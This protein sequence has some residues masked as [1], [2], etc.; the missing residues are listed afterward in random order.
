MACHASHA[1]RCADKK[2]ADENRVFVF[3][4]TNSYFQNNVKIS[5]TRQSGF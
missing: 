5:L 4:K 1:L 3:K 2:M